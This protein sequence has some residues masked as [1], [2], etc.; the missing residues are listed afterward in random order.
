M[1]PIYICEDD[2]MILAAQKKFLEKQIMMEGYDMQIAL[3]SRHPQEIIAAVAA[4][5]KRGIYFLDVELKDEAM[6]GFMLGQQIRKF[7]ARGFLIYV[8]SFPDLAFETFRY[9]LEALDYIVK[10]NSEKMLAGMH[11]NLAIITERMCK[12]QG[13]QKEYFTVKVLDI[14]K[15]IPVD[16]IM[17]FETS[18]RTHRIELH[19]KNDCIDFIGSMQELQEQFREH[20]LRV[21][22]SYLVN[23]NQIQELDLKHREILMDNGEKCLFSKSMKGKLLSRI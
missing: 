8:T 15:H 6:D 9:H 18:A 11:K 19:A 5:P 23:V 20:F 14:V 21:H 4:S 2:A 13:E 7:D 1:L 3:C 12:E 10:G 17:F 22:R 16:E